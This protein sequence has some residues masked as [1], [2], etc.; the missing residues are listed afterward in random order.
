[1]KKIL[2]LLAC[3][4]LTCSAQLS[5][6][7]VQGGVGFTNIDYDGIGDIGV[8]YASLGY[9]IK[10]EGSDFSFTPHIRF[11][12]SVSDAEISERGTDV[13][14][15]I[16]TYFLAGVKVQYNQNNFYAYINPH[17]TYIEN[18]AESSSFYGSNSITEDAS[19]FGIGLGAGYNFSS[20]VS[21]EGNIEFY[22]DVT[23]YGA[24]ILYKF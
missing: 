6:S 12:T 16:N 22:E 8:T 4:L 15:S 14:L 18:E 23:A 20:N 11:G 3:S 17:I 9:E 19:E 13:E 2:S 1:M 7:K 21:L 24:G 10:S 5:G